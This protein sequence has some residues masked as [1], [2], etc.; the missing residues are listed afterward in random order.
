MKIDLCVIVTKSL[1]ITLQKVIA[2][3]SGYFSLHNKPPQ[4][5]VAKNNNIYFDHEFV[6]RSELGSHQL[7]STLLG[8]SWGSP[9]TGW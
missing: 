8:F 2:L 4:S 3:C 6:S 7:V 9:K 5:L 1:V